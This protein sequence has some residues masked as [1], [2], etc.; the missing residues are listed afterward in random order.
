M[1]LDIKLMALALAAVFAGCS[2]SADKPEPDD[3]D[4]CKI[5]WTPES[6]LKGESVSF[7]VSG[8]E[9]IVKSVLWTFGDKGTSTSSG[10]AS[11]SHIYENAGTY[12]VQAYL[13]MKAGGMQELSASVTVSDTDLAMQLSNTFPARM[14]SVTFAVTNVSGIKSV[15]WDFGDGQTENALSAVHQYSADGEYVAKAAVSMDGGKTVNL[16]QT[17]KVEGESLSYACRNFTKGG[18]VW[19]MAHRGNVDAGYGYAPNSLASY[20]KC[21]ESGCV[22]FIETDVQITR[23]GVV[24]CLHDNY[25]SRFTDYSS[26]ASDYGYVAQFTYDEIKKYRIKTTDGKVT[27]QI[28]PTLKEVLTEFRGKVWFNLDKCA[29][30]SKDTEAIAKVYEVVKECGCLD[31]VQFYIGNS[32]T[33]NAKWLTSQTQP[34]ILSPHANSSSQLSAVTGYK[35]FWYFVQVSTDTIKNDISWLRTA[36]TS[37]LT[38]TNILDD[39]GQAFKDGNTTLIDKFVNAG[40]DM[41]QCD[42]PVEM[43]KHLRSLGKRR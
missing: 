26:Y 43:D 5:V 38:I 19:I 40:L 22:D 28:V 3:E 34:A 8:V 41:V 17:V 29:D 42:Y 9:G 25:L 13:T 11:I 1:A 24:I 32:G 6:P 16:T 10:D 39:N 18:Q 14:E 35:P 15:S 27:D 37:G 36:G 21:V 20:R 7:S 30:T 31:R 23:D 2:G 33:V 12:N 4:V